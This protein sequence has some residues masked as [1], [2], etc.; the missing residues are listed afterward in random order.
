[1]QF[2]AVDAFPAM[3][4]ISFMLIITR[5]GLGW[6][7][8]ANMDSTTDRIGSV[9]RFNGRPSHGLVSDT[10]PMHTLAVN[11]S[12]SVDRTDEYHVGSVGYDETFTKSNI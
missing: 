5:V 3:A 7:Q 1:M 6:A 10:I 9:S 11:I 4:G 2:I 12:K 8:K